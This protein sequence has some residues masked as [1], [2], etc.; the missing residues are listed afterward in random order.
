MVSNRLSDTTNNKN[1][2]NSNNYSTINTNLLVNEIKESKPK[3]SAL[4]A[5]LNEIKSDNSSVSNSPVRNN[6]FNPNKVSLL[7]SSNNNNA[8]DRS[9]SRDSNI[10]MHRKGREMKRDNSNFSGKSRDFD[11]KDMKS[12]I[13]NIQ[14]KIDGLEKK[15]CNI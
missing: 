1:S 8:K 9:E 10:N 15:L 5:L 4:R 11:F 3:S 7:E 12:E 2:S 14:E 13:T 6:K